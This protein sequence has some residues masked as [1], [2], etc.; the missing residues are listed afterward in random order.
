MWVQLY[1]HEPTL[2]LS[3]EGGWEG[4]GAPAL[5]LAEDVLGQW[6]LFRWVH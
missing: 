6:V 3:R 2:V 4:G 1:S 5:N